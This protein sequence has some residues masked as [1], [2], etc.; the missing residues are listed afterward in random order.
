MIGSVMF[1][2]RFVWWLVIVW[3]VSS[4]RSCCVCLFIVNILII[5][6]LLVCVR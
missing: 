2:L 5:L 4:C 3:L 1:G 6:F